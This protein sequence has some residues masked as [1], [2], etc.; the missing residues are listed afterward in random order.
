MTKW[1]KSIDIMDL[2]LDKCIKFP[3]KL[4]EE[5]KQNKIE[6]KRKSVNA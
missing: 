3:L 2:H 6:R 1:G 5:V 4:A